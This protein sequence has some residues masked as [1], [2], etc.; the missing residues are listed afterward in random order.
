MAKPLLR[1]AA[2]VVAFSAPSIVAAI[3]T[4]LDHSSL[5]NAPSYAAA[6]PILIWGSIFFAVLVPAGLILTS[7]QSWPRRVGLT[8]LML[9]LLV[10]ECTIAFYVALMPALG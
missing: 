9:C 5:R 10:L 3:G 1:W 2:G 7:K 8:L 6:A 4:R